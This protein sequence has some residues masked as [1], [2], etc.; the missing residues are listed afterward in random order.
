MLSAWLLADTGARVVLLEQGQP[1]Q[2]SS[3]AGGGIMSPLY[4]WR[5]PASVIQLAVQAYEFYP[6]F[7]DM[8]ETS[9]GVAIGFERCGLIVQDQVDRHVLSGL[10]EPLQ[11]TR[12]DGANRLCDAL[13]SGDPALYFADIAQIRPP[14]LVKALRQVLARRVDVRAYTPVR[15]LDVRG[16]RVHGVE[17][18]S[19]TLRCGE[20]VVCAGAWTGRLLDAA[21]VSVPIR[22]I[23]GQMIAYKLDERPFVP[24]VL[25]DGKYLIPRADGLVLVGSSVEDVGFDQTVTS[26]VRAELEAF[27]GRICPMLAG[28]PVVSHWSGL[29]PGAPSGVPFVGA[30]PGIDGLWLN[31]G[32]F[33]NGICL[34]PGACRLL[35]D[36]MQSGAPS[37]EGAAFSVEAER[38][39][40]WH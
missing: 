22:P 14:R 8:L 11:P 10:P 21:G 3:W 2:Q 37:E 35:V 23:R 40:I 29:R 28:R 31:A 18:E 27:A 1:G 13:V 26:D 5:Y 30:F 17:C 34:A 6:A 25:A 7:V 39:E 12:T 36:W 15:Q 4:P 16:G 24:M 38:P 20:V 33:R 9:T 32:H 19:G